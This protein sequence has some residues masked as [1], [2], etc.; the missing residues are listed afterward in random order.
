MLMNLVQRASFAYDIDAPVHRPSRKYTRVKTPPP[1]AKKEAR[2]D[3]GSAF[4]RFFPIGWAPGG[5]LVHLGRLGGPSSQ[6]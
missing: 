1:V 4:G 6:S 5:K 2:V 3:A